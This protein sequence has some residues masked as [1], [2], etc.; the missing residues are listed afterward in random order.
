MTAAA[1][2]VVARVVS[3]NVGV[4]RLVEHRGRRAWT[5]IWKHPVAGR[6]AVRGVN[7]DGDEQADRRVHG[8]PDKAVYAYA[9][10]DYTWWAAELGRQLE[11]GTFGEN[12]TLEGVDLGAARVGERWQVG[13]TVLEVAQPRTPCWKL[14]LRMGDD[15][16]PARFLA[17]GRPGAYLR[18]VGEG[19]VGAAD[20]VVSLHRPDD[21]PSLAEVAVERGRRRS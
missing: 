16:F 4:P 20:E 11:P 2:L 9:S 13:S 8:G 5:G 3:V 7:L 21:R 18:I 10:E 1:P 12:L 14:G 17:A 15:E 19:E 6:V